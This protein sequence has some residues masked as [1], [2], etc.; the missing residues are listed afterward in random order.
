MAEQ[1]DEEKKN[2]RFA[3]TGSV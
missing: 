3:N 2:W 1:T